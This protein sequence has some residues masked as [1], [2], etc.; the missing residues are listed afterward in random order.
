[1]ASSP[2]A[3]SSDTISTIS[4]SVST[5]DRVSTYGSDSAPL[6]RRR[7]PAA[8]RQRIPEDKLGRDARAEDN[9]KDRHNPG[10]WA[11]RSARYSEVARGQA[12]GHTGQANPDMVQ[13]RRQT[14]GYRHRFGHR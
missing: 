9:F 13:L 2:W 11:G 4:S 6:R 14:D 12:T 1:M 3:R 8:K 5:S 10:R 7:R